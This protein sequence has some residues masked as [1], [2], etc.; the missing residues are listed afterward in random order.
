MVNQWGKLHV[1]K[2]L[3]LALFKR[4][5]ILQSNLKAIKHEKKQTFSFVL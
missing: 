5:L 1:K 3:L 2:S 4:T